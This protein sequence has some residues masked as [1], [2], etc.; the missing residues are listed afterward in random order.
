MQVSQPTLFGKLMSLFAGVALSGA[1]LAAT[2]AASP[3]TP[4]VEI[5]TTMGDIVVELNGEKAPKTVDNF[6]TYVKAGFYKGTIFHRVIDGFMIQGGGF[7]EKLVQK[8][9]NKP[10]PIESQN[11]LTNNTYTIA[12]ARTGDPNSATSQFFINVADN[13]ALNYPGRDGFGYTV[14]GKVVKGQEVVDRIKAVL[15]DDKGSFQNIP[16]V[17]VVIKSAT[18]L[19]TPIAPKQ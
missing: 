13:D 3:T 10:V 15:V 12:M 2:P 6:I 16:V 7:D 8:K 11:G 19:K 1:A 4:Q 17:P 9:T 5:K 14:F 18:I